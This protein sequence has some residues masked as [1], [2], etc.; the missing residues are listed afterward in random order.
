[1][2][3]RLIATLRPHRLPD[4]REAGPEETVMAAPPDAAMRFAPMVPL[5]PPPAVNDDP[6]EALCEAV[7]AALRD[8]GYLSEPPAE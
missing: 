4:D 3:G 1:M 6:D 5:A 8:A 2:I 7:E